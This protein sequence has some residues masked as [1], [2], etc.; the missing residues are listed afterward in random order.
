MNHFYAMN[1]NLVE[2]LKIARSGNTLG[3]KNSSFIINRFQGMEETIEW[4]IESIS[5]NNYISF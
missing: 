5:I 2:Q 1:H 3:V 4:Y